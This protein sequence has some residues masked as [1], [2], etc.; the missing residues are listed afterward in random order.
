MKFSDTSDKAIPVHCIGQDSL[1]EKCKTLDPVTR[2]W[3]RQNNFLGSFGQSVICPTESGDTIALLGLG[4]KHSR[5]RSRF[6]LAAAAK[7]LPPG[8]YEIPAR[9]THKKLL[10]GRKN[11]W[12][13]YKLSEYAKM[14]W[15][16]KWKK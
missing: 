15:F 1:I 11:E 5:N 3:I 16:R 4:D 12:C 7:S 8:N 13:T 6:S 14:K 2:D 10:K 9:Y